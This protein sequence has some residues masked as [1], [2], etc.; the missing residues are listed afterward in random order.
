M[1]IAAQQGMPARRAQPGEEARWEGGGALGQR[2]VN[3][4]DDPDS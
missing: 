3:Q 2:K 4:G 1:E